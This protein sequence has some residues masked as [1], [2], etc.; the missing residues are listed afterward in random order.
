MRLLCDHHPAALEFIS[1]REDIGGMSQAF[2]RPTTAIGK[3]R[4]DNNI[5]TDAVVASGIARLAT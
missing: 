5:A 1:R 4:T 2:S 3:I